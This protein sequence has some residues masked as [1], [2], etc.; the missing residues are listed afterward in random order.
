MPKRGLS[1]AGK[2]IIDSENVISIYYFQVPIFGEMLQA[3]YT[4][5]LRQL[6]TA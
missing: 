1:L 5:L 3:A 6:G 4:A 2:Y